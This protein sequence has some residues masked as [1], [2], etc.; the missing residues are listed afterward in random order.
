LK[1]FSQNF[2]LSDSIPLLVDVEKEKNEIFE[3]GLSESI[4][5]SNNMPESNILKKMFFM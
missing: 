2:K 1:I 3:I 5:A 4:F